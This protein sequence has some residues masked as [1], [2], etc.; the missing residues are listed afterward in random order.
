MCETN[1]S[2]YKKVNKEGSCN[3]EDHKKWN[4]RSFLQA[5]GLAGGGSMMLANTPLSVSRPSPLSMA[6]SQAPSDDKVLILVRLQGG[7]DGFNTII[8][9]YDYDVYANARPLIRIPPSEFINLQQNEFAMPKPMNKL[10]GV[11]GDGKMRVVHGVGYEDSSLSHFKGSDIYAN[12]NLQ[13]DDRTGFMGRY[14]GEIYPDYFF[15]PPASPPS[16]QIG[17]IGNLIFKGPE[18]DYSFAV[19][20]PRRLLQII[21]NET[22]YNLDGLEDCTYDDKVR[23]LREATNTTFNYADVISAAYERSSDFGGYLDD[24]L[25]RQLSIISRLIKG[26]LG[27]KVY[28]VTLGGFDTHNNQIQRHQQLLNSFSEA[29]SNFY[30]DLTASGW[31]DKVLTTTISEFGRRFRENGSLGT[32]HGTAAPMMFFGTALNGNGFAGEH[33]DMNNLTRGGNVTNTTDFRRVYA[34]IMKDWLCI[35]EDTV[36]RALL[37]TNGGPFESLDLGFNCSGTNPSI[38]GAGDG[39]VHNVSYTNSNDSDATNDNKPVINIVPNQT[40]HVNVDL[41]NIIGQ[42]VATLRNEMMMEGVAYSIN[43]KDEAKTRLSTGQYVYLIQT[44]DTEYSKSLI[45]S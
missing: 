18:S 12:T 3:T 10:E 8:P 19:S 40:A 16:I 27:T 4:R 2:K 34:T 43:V 33:P 26:N 23:F 29:I 39:L 41:Y 30:A 44:N 31:D 5:L 32:D 15:N 14:F 38:P 45:I 9:V 28:L 35:D 22:F 11:W 1:H 6:L 42:K 21:E 20:N 37:D 24:S 25:G 36:G 7:N 17:S 13:E